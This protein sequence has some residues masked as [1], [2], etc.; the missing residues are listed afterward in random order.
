[1]A[2]L[3]TVGNR[4]GGFGARII[5]RNAPV[6]GQGGGHL[7]RGARLVEAAKLLQKIAAPA[8]QQ[9]VVPQRRPFRGRALDVASLR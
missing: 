5:S 8:R 4:A 7:E 1:M 3:E 9:M 2:E 6:P